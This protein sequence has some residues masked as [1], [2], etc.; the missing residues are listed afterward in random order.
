ML[1]VLGVEPQ[2]TTTE[3]IDRLYHWPSIIRQP[4]RVQVA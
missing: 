2:A 4:A 3:V 1:P